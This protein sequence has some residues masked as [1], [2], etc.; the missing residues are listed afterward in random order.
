MAQSRKVLLT[1]EII[2]QIKGKLDDL[3]GKEVNEGAIFAL[4]SSGELSDQDLSGVTGG[5]TAAWSIE[6]R[7]H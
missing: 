2:A 4:G 1:K 3:E 7:R 6:I 5:L